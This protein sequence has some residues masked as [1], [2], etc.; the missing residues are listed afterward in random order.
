MKNPLLVVFFLTILFIFGCG[1]ETK[2]TKPVQQ[3]PDTKVPDS[4]K[5]PTSEEQITKNLLAYYQAIEGK[6]I[7]IDGYFAPI[8][9]RFYSQKNQRND[10]V[11]AII[12][13]GYS[14][15]QDRKIT[16]DLASIDISSVG[17]NFEVDFQGHGSTLLS[18]ETERKEED[19]HNLFVFD[20]NYKIIQYGAFESPEGLTSKSNTSTLAGEA[21]SEVNKIIS[22][23]LK[24]SN[25]AEADKCIH[26]GTGVIYLT[27]SGAFDAIYVCKT[28]ADIPQYS[29]W[30]KE[31][32]KEIRCK[33]QLET[34]P[35]FDCEDFSKAGCFLDKTNNYNRI[36]S[37]INSLQE[38]ELINLTDQQITQAKILE[39][40][41]QVQLVITEQGLA[42]YFGK[43]DGEWRL[44]VIDGA[45][46]D[47][48]A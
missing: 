16:I 27:K 10:K 22:S 19:F 44:L 1:N 32:L 48:S 7:D 33:I 29:P 12:R 20:Q 23:E 46:F 30:M 2:T 13:N 21:L 45:V 5:E 31:S 43:I 17:S 35:K 25:L 41:V 36:S 38:N 47:C 15:I 39:K 42:L 37:V 24:K 4:P 8:V 26:P 28:L 11:G 40:Q 34:V 3:N 6:E 14:R 9:E 18:G